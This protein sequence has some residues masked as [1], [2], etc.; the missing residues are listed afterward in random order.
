M[1]GLRI[2]QRFILRQVLGNQRGDGTRI[3]LASDTM[4][5]GTPVVI[6]SIILP[7]DLVADRLHFIKSIDNYLS[8]LHPGIARPIEVILDHSSPGSLQ[9]VSEYV[10]G[11]S[12][13]PTVKFLSTDEFLDLLAQFCAALHFL[14]S[15]GFVHLDLQPSNILLVPPQTHDMRWILKLIDL[16]F[17]KLAE[18]ITRKDLVSFSRAYSAPE[19]LAGAS[20]DHRADLY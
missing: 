2:S 12:I 11:Q 6:K 7:P 10:A 15:R 5:H 9:L 13:F 3:V 18:L 1:Q 20:F 17:L 16:P 19:L 4:C 8:L 14:H